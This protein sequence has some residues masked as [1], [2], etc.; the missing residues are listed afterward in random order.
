MP[1][2]GSE[3]SVLHVLPH[4]GGGGETYVDLLDDMPGYRFTKVYLAPSPRPTPLELLHGVVRVF[5]RARRYDLVH[6]HGEIAAGVCV[7]VLAT[8]RAVVTLHGLHLV[9]RSMGLRRSLAALNL[10][11]VL[12]TAGATICVSWSEHDELRRVVGGKTARRAIVIRN[13][14]PIPP[15]LR[16][17]ERAAVRDE[18]GISSDQVV[19]IWVGSLDERKDPLTAVHA[20]TKAGTTLLVV[21]D[22]PLRPEVERVAADTNVRV[23]GQR[24][25]IERLLTAAELYILTSRR[26]GLSLSLLEAMAA[27]LVPIVTDLAENLEAVGDSGLV[28]PCGDSAELAGVLERVESGER[29]SAVGAAARTRSGELFASE[30]MVR[31]T[32]AVYDEILA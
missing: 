32:N 27:G 18:L 25:D 10:R 11:L 16:E 30:R 31:Q 23:L 13:G 26:E 6:V 20:A 4:P 3:C 14:V 5:R 1:M 12:R 2:P 15:P 28:V 22:G 7:P 9:R 19:G 24:N 21:G 17:S 29:P 8:H